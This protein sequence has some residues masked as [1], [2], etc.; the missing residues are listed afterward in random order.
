VPA[1]LPVTGTGY[2]VNIWV[3]GAQIARWVDITSL[4][5]A[6]SG[7]QQVGDASFTVTDPAMVVSVLTD[8]AYVHIA[9][10]QGSLFK[11]FVR[12]RRPKI[13]AAG[14]RVEVTC[15]DVSSLLDT[16]L[17]VS[18][19]RAAGESDKARIQYL[20]ATYGSQGIYNNG[21]GST[22]TS[23]IRTLRSNM[24]RQRF[25]NM[26]LRQAIESVLGLASESSNYYVDNLGRIVT[27]DNSN[28]INDNA[29]YVVRVAH[30]LAGGQVAPGELVIDFDTDTLFND[31]QVRAK[32]RSA[33]V[34]V[35]DLASINKYGRRA[36]Y[37]DAPDAE[38]VEK[39]TAVGNAALLDDAAPKARGSFHV[40][41]PFD[42]N[43]SNRWRPGQMVTLHSAAHGLA[44][45]QSRI[46]GV[47]W[48][49]LSP[50]GARR[51]LIRFGGDRLRLSSR[52]TANVV[53]A[54]ISGQIS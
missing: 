27:F 37:I 31:Y 15:R 33:D 7:N 51:A 41:S 2:V 23:Q 19:D 26:T 11:G 18:N 24:P 10:A 4:A 44:G 43:G 25:R 34:R 50:E 40:E 1:W 29:P 48:E 53:G 21:I 8:E 52:G 45:A 9:D 16:T 5:I 47:E 20:L 22:D 14:R 3:N 39:A 54:A 49:Y 46:V 35:A 38:T 30:T 17:V 32:V 13:V 6:E 12:S 28:P 36:R 42:R